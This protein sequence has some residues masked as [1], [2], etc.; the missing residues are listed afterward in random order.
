MNFA[1]LALTVMLAS[2]CAASPDV[3]FVVPPSPE[4]PRGG[5]RGTSVVTGQ[6]PAFPA[7]AAAVCAGANEHGLA[8]DCDDLAA[9]ELRTAPTLAAT[10]TACGHPTVGCYFPTH[11]VAFIPIPGSPVVVPAGTVAAEFVCGRE[12]GC[13]LDPDEVLLHELVHAAGASAHDAE[14]R[15]VYKLAAARLGR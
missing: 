5:W 10:E 14:F 2:G 11:H 1:R 15:A 7:T 3:N 13:T 8:V 4:L 9:V 12:A 6:I